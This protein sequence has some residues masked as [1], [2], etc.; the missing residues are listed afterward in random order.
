MF[1]S[2]EDIR[3]CLLIDEVDAI[4]GSRGK[5]DAHEDLRTLINA[6]FRQGAV[7]GRMVGDGA[8]MMPK[9][10]PVFTP[11]AAGRD[12]RLPTRDRGPT[13]AVVIEL[14][15]SFPRRCRSASPASR[16][17]GPVRSSPA[18]ARSMGARNLDDLADAI[19]MMPSGIT[20]RAGRHVG[21]ASIAIADQAGGDWPDRAGMAPKAGTRS[22]DPPGIPSSPRRHC[23]DTVHAH[24][25]SHANQ[26]DQGTAA[27][28]RV[29][30]PVCIG[31][32]PSPRCDHVA[33]AKAP[34]HGVRG[35][36]LG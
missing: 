31:L 14:Q 1:R 8:G 20:D 17:R 10:F 11:V 36:A 6:G 18:S 12:R 2:I 21:V 29:R 22:A 26:P 9:E 24:D 4:F 32:K 23:H 15:T 30:R 19:P 7:V 16:C 27:E 25:A 33:A 3:A 5:N 34:P 35:G 28:A 13:R